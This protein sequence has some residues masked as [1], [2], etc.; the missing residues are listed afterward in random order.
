MP[1][2]S[3]WSAEVKAETLMWWR[4]KS[5]GLGVRQTPA[6][7][8]LLSS[9]SLCSENG[10]VHLRNGGEASKP[11]PGRFFE[12]QARFGNIFKVVVIYQT[13]CVTTK[14]CQTLF[15]SWKRLEHKL[16]RNEPF[17]HR[18]ISCAKSCGRERHSLQNS[19]DANFSGEQWTIWVDGILNLSSAPKCRVF[20]LQL[21]ACHRDRACCLFTKHLWVRVWSCCL[22]HNGIAFDQIF[23]EKGVGRMGN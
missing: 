3:W 21:P 14:C 7:V 9:L 6:Q 23:S 13:S 22:V 19:L 20:G 8:V 11:Q 10:L 5:Q 12:N 2:F 17:V 1:L 4:L 16:D 15:V 18:Q